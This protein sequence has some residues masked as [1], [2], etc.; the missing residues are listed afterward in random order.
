MA[1]TIT[2][3]NAPLVSF[4]TGQV[5]WRD[6]GA[7][8]VGCAALHYV[9]LGFAACGGEP[10]V[11]QDDKAEGDVGRRDEVVVDACLLGAVAL[12]ESRDHHA[13]GV[14]RQ[15]FQHVRRTYHF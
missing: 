8:T 13:R 1:A 5:C 11:L 3:Y 10:G 15:L 14:N 9:K 2:A 6:H 7:L 12:P 4:S